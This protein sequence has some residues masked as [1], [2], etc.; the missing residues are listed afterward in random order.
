MAP[1]AVFCDQLFTVS[2]TFICFPN[3]GST[4]L[5]VGPSGTANILVYRYGVQVVNYTVGETGLTLESPASAND[6]YLVVQ[7][8]TMTPASAA[9]PEAPVVPDEPFVRVDGTWEPLQDF[10]DAGAFVG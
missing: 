8:S 9:V 6:V 2:S 4:L 3:Q 5:Q 7:T 10:L 1:F